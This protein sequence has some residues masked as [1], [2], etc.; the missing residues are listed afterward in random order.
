MSTW[1]GLSK[2]LILGHIYITN[3]IIQSAES[4]PDRDAIANQLQI[5][6]DYGVVKG[7]NKHFFP[8]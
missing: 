7:S 1:G 3:K 5:V 4:D 6:I 2:L 8:T